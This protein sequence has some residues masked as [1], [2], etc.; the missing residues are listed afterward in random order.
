MGELIVGMILLAGAALLYQHSGGNPAL[1]LGAV[2]IGIV[3]AILLA[4]GLLAVVDEDTAEAGVP[5]HVGKGVPSTSPES[6]PIGRG[7]VP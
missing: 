4:F 7:V 6:S 1:V 3:G 5:C 2:V